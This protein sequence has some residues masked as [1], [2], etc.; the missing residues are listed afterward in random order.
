M[1]QFKIRC[2]Q[3]GQ[4]MTNGTKGNPI[5]KTVESYL[6][7]W[8]KEQL[9]GRRKEFTSKYTD[10]GNQVEQQSIDFIADQLGYGMLFKNEQHFENEFLTGTPDIKITKKIIDAKNSWDCFTFPLFETEINNDYFLQGQGYMDL[11]DSDSYE[12]VY[13][14]TDTPEDLIIREAQSYCY[15]NNIELDDEILNKFIKKMTYKDIPDHLKIKVFPFKRD[16]EVINSIYERVKLC[17]E[18]ISKKL[19][20]NKHLF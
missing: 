17:R 16:Q 19:E 20:A 12:L 15:K 5:G 3:I 1:K 11:T 18:Y 4:I 2:S 14:L 13:C 6:D 10:K 7:G 8:I 9:Y